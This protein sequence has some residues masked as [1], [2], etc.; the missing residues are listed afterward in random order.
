MN[1]AYFNVSGVDQSEG[2][3]TVF[4]RSRNGDP[5]ND[6]PLGSGP[7]VG[8]GILLPGIQV[9]QFSITFLLPDG[10][11]ADSIVVSR[12]KSGA[13]LLAGV[14]ITRCLIDAEASC[15]GRLFRIT[16]GIPDNPPTHSD[17]TSAASH[18]IKRGPI[19]MAQ[20]TGLEP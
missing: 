7:V 9:G 14:T 11:S 6:I 15:G 2:A 20:Q 1:G 10:C 16:R 3:G 8:N 13:E 17:A 5:D 4:V 12:D 19:V 18:F